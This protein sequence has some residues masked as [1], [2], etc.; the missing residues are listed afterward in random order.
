MAFLITHHFDMQLQRESNKKIISLNDSLILGSGGEA[1]VYELP[2]E[3]TLVAKVYHK[4]TDVRAR[5]LATMLANP[6][7]DPMA[8][9][10]HVSIAWPIDQLRAANG[11]RQ[12][13]GFLMPRVADMYPIIDFY[14]PRTRRQQCPLF[15][16]FYLHRT[17]HNL[18]AAVRAIHECG[19]VIGDV[20]ES[21]ILVADTALVTLVDTDSFQV[22]D[23]DNGSVYRCPVGKPDFTPPELQGKNFADIDRAPAHDL[24]GL[25]VLI[26]QLLMEGIHPFAGI[27]EGEGEPPPYEKRISS[28]HFPY[29]RWRKRRV[30]Y[31]PTPTAL[32]F[33]VVH[34]L[35]RK[36]FVRCFVK[37]H[38]K[39]RTRTTAREWQLALE[40]AENELVTCSVND[41]HRYGRH[42]NSCP[43]CERTKQLN[44][45]DPFPSPSATQKPLSGASSLSTAHKPSGFQPFHLRSGV[46]A[47][48]LSELATKIDANWEDGKYHLYQGDL[49]NWL[50]A[51]GR[52]D[53]AS[54]ARN[55]ISTES[56][57]DIG[58]EKFL[59][60]FDTDAPPAP[61]LKVSDTT[62][63]FGKVNV[64]AI[65]K[66][67]YVKTFRIFNS[68]RGHLF[69]TVSSS[70]SWLQI[71]VA[72]FSDNNTT[73]TAKATQP[74]S[75]ANIIVTSNGGTVTIP[76]MMN[77]T[78][79]WFKTVL[80]AG[81]IGVGIASGFRL[82]A[83]APLWV[84]SKDI[85]GWFPNS[86]L[87]LK[88]LLDSWYNTENMVGE[89]FCIILLALSIPSMAGLLVAQLWKKLKF[90]M[91]L[92]ISLSI[93][94]SICFA[95]TF[96][97]CPF[98]LIA[99]WGIDFAIQPS[100]SFISSISICGWGITGLLIGFAIGLLKWL[101][102]IR[103]TLMYPVVIGGLL[104]AFFLFWA[105]GTIIG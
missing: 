19:Y 36:L 55:I 13:V 35:L 33:G 57:K 5:K 28:G 18:A 94:S 73:V 38:S 14:N 1:R 102:K 56:D 64:E 87:H 48:S 80:I 20:N 89:K 27:F 10:K 24:F 63:N 52:A 75:R 41:Q 12:I 2:N 45:R 74:G 77:P 44:G 54:K 61:E 88:E 93:W 71:N 50:G 67:K 100:F 15:N 97:I 86:L 4:P 43:W 23:L 91:T 46:V 84:L 70:E 65:P 104:F 34:P 22:C 72:K 25:A 76:I 30:P 17:A 96:I 29:G 82:F 47:N 58:I 31:S 42:L 92:P 53:I 81:M 78:Y 90:K 8:K 83:A 49:A 60:S 6:P 39:P 95:L 37:G 40:E 105:V 16:Y 51:I 32:P 7:V 21:N 66:E 59:Q 11:S 79:T 69:G 101:R 62:L 26:F 99:V 3:D 85:W 98:S 68:S 103:K 9:H